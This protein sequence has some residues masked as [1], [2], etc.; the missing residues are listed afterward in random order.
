MKEI[1]NAVNFERIFYLP[2]E[3]TSQLKKIEVFRRNQAKQ[4]LSALDFAICNGWNYG[5]F[6]E[7]LSYSDDKIQIPFSHECRLLGNGRDRFN[8]KKSVFAAQLEVVVVAN[9]LWMRQQLEAFKINRN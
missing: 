1:V 9:Y 6:N 5:K 7:L 8:D 4:S 3:I 2:D